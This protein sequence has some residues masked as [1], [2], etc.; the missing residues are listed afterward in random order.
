[1][2]LGVN[3]TIIFLKK[4]V[5]RTLYHCQFACFVD[6]WQHVEC[7]ITMKSLVLG[8]RLITSGYLTYVAYIETL[9][10]MVTFG[11]KLLQ[12]LRPKISWERSNVALMLKECG[13]I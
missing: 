13:Y 2:V 10:T 8:K 9:N 6:M 11:W 3:I 5:L 12:N 7:K 4:Y 1:M